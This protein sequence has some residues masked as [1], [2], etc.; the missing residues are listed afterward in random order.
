[1]SRARLGLRPRK[2]YYGALAGILLVGA[3]LTVAAV[4]LTG[5]GRDILINLGASVIGVFLVAV[6][7]DAFRAPLPDA[8][9]PYFR[10]RV[11]NTLPPA[12]LYRWDHRADQLILP[13]GNRR[14][15]EVRH[16]ETPVTAGL[17]AFV[18]E[19][20]TLLW[21][22]PRTQDLAA[23]LRLPVEIPEAGGTVHVRYVECEDVGYAIDPRLAGAGPVVADDDEAW[24][25]ILEFYAIKYGIP[26]RGT[27][28]GTVRWT[29]YE[30]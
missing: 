28:P 23:Y 10:V 22:D 21:N 1:M 17:G 30:S 18:D 11:Y 5:I 4:P 27:L 16:Y 24:P 8:Q 15:A 6:A 25:V 19:Q 13:G 26:G 29:P 20:F 2:L 9:R 12:R 7:L 14:G 3:A